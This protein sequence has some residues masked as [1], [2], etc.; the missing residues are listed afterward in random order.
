MDEKVDMKSRVPTL[1]ADNW[2]VWSKKMVLLLKLNRC[3]SV[4]ASAATSAG[5]SA[6]GVPEAQSAQQEEVDAKTDEQALALIG[7]HCGDFIVYLSKHLMEAFG[8]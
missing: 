7:L 8:D 2:P 1:N 6:G 4:V 3:F 5:S